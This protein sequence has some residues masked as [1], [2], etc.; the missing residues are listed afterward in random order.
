MMSSIFLGTFF[1]YLILQSKNKKFL[2]WKICLSIIL[3]LLFSAYFWIP[4]Y[5][6]KQYTMVYLLTQQNADF[7][8]YFVCIKQFFNSPWGY[9]GSIP[10]CNDGIS[11]QV[12]QA[13]L[14]LAVVS[15]V[16]STYFLWKKRKGYGIALLFLLLFSFSLFIQTKYSAFIWDMIQPF[17]Y[18]QFPWRF[19]IFSDFTIAFLTAYIFSQLKR[20]K[21]KILIASI[22]ILLLILL[23]KDY[24]R[25][26]KYMTNI[27]D[28]NYTDLS[29][30]RWRTSNM[31]YEYTPKGIAIVQPSSGNAVINIKPQEIPTKS[32]SVIRGKMSVIPIED[33]TQQKIWQITVLQPGILGLNTFSFPGWKTFID[34]KEVS[35]TDTNKFKLITVAVPSGKH[36]VRATFTDTPVRTIANLLSLI[37][38]IGVISYGLLIRKKYGNNK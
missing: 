12:G 6:E 24:F 14:L 13:Q 10:G 27:T 23:N 34:N 21:L 38:I 33:I 2:F 19:L 17:S 9:G 16:F 37:T 36:S 32:F 29:V 8:L 18:I 25:P 7:H 31:S 4:A 26:E 1:I 11:F 20:E 3:G 28:E 15:L 22:M 30:I 35:Y 5:F